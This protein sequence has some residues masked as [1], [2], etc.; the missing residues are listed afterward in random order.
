MHVFTRRRR[1]SVAAI[2]AFLTF[3]LSSCTI[4]YVTIPAGYDTVFVG[5]GP[6][7]TGAIPPPLYFP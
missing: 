4:G 1:W 7:Y 3:A 5:C 2:G 6:R